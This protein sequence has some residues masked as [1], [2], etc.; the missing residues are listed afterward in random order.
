MSKMKSSTSILFVL[1]AFLCTTPVF[2]QAFT[3]TLTGAVTDPNGASVPGASVKA[4]NISTNET[5]RTLTDGEGRFAVTQ[6][7]PGDYEVTAEAK[8]FKIFVQKALTL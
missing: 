8:G 7:L 4:Q 6:L 2:G 5:R 3:A 1:A